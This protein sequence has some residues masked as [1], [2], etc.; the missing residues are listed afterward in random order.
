M[1]LSTTEKLRRR[2]QIGDGFEQRDQIGEAVGWVLGCG[3]IGVG[4]VGFI[5]DGFEDDGE[6]EAAQSDRR[7][8]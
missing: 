4:L 7:W 5:G 8:V 2:D 3:E 6:A 1:G